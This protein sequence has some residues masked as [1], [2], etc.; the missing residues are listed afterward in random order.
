MVAIGSEL[1]LE[2]EPHPLDGSGPLLNVGVLMRG[3]VWFGVVPARWSSP[4]TFAP[5]PA[6]TRAAVRGARRRWLDRRRARIRG[7]TPS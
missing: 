2:H 5:S 4:A 7:S 6:L 3:G 1:E